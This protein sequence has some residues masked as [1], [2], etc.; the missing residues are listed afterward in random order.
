M[1]NALEL[2]NISVVFGEGTPFRK[3]ALKNIN[4]VFN[5][6]EI[7]GIIGH[8]GSGKSTLASLLNGLLKPTAGE[9]LLCRVGVPISRI[10]AF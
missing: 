8:T 2:K 6:G 9:V 3:D 4:T 1:A 5:K 7:T 10:S